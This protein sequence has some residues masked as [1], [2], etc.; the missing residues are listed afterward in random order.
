MKE[1]EKLNETLLLEEIQLCLISF[2]NNCGFGNVAEDINNQ[3]LSPKAKIRKFVNYYK[4]KKTAFA[5]VLVFV[6]DDVDT[7]T[8]MQALQAAS[9]LHTNLEIASVKLWICIRNVTLETKYSKETRTFLKSFY[10]DELYLPKVYL[11]DIIDHRIRHMKKQRG[12]KETALNPYSKSLCAVVENLHFGHLRRAL[13]FLERIIEE[14]LPQ[15]F[16]VDTDVEVI[17]KYIEKSAHR[18]FI[19][20]G[21]L[22]NIHD[23]IHRATK[24]FPVIYE[25][26]NLL[27][28]YDE[29]GIFLYSL[30]ND[31]IQ[32]KASR[33]QKLE[34][35]ELRIRDTDFKSAIKWL[36]DNE[37]IEDIGNNRI[38]LT[39]K[40][41]SLTAVMNTKYYTVLCKELI[42]NGFVPNVYWQF[43]EIP[44]DYQ[45]III[46]KYSWYREFTGSE[47]K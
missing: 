9:L 36:F 41:K 7:A 1:N 16:G 31:V 39:I 33:I 37:V 12:V 27:K 29:I 25:L 15:D 3:N 32:N 11:F 40:G 10:P 42:Q 30:L 17:R 6:L 26:L 18:I 43:I 34:D 35:T 46:N 13:S 24:A 20:R 23:P 22:P 4:D 47:T 19:K 5:K 21:V 28:Y 14:V 8:D 2:F 38:M 45:E 44:M